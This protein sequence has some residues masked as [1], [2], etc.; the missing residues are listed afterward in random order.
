[1]VIGSLEPMIYF[2]A[3]AIHKPLSNNFD[4]L[5]FLITDQTTN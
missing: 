5:E 4:S 1:M 2:T 3:N